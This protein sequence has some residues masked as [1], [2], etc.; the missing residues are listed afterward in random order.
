ML[1]PP[2]RNSH[3]DTYCVDENSD[4]LLG[5]GM[6][7]ARRSFSEDEEGFLRR[8][9][10]SSSSRSSSRRRSS[11]LLPGTPPGAEGAVS[12]SL[13]RRSINEEKLLEKIAA[14]GASAA[15]SS[16]HRRRHS[17]GYG[18]RSS[19]LLTRRGSTLERGISAFLRD[20]K[21]EP[22]SANRPL[23]I[24]QIACGRHHM[25]VL[26]RSGAVFTVGHGEDGRLGLGSLRSAASYSQ[27]I[28]LNTTSVDQF[29]QDPSYA[30]T[31]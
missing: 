9:S 28:R 24:V 1:R 30:V 15:T 19:A 5:L 16:S 20:K 17:S 10:C 3:T 29:E 22:L 13:R 25:A 21:A 14:A 26:A 8:G 2:M 23:S 27:K 11:G 4:L 18:L 6:T 31:K 12:T 7:S